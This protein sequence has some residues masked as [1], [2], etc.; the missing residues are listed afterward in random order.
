VEQV[1][2]LQQV[3]LKVCL[4]EIDQVVDQMVL[5]ELVVDL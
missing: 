4:V 5:V 1:I 3:Q 2:L